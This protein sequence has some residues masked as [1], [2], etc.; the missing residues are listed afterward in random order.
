MCALEL[1]LRLSPAQPGSK[2]QVSSSADR[3]DSREFQAP[4]APGSQLVPPFTFLMRKLEIQEVKKGGLCRAPGILR[5]RPL[6]SHNGA[7]R[8]GPWSHL[9][10]RKRPRLEAGGGL[11]TE[12]LA[13]LL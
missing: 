8:R 6:S 7:D 12:G 11:Q 4:R 9:A 1:P 5:G 3:S 13:P 2:K 10:Q